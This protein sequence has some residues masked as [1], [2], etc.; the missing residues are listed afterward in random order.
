[1]N[2][3]EKLNEWMRSTVGCH[4]TQQSKWLSAIPEARENTT[5]N[6]NKV[7]GAATQTWLLKNSV[8]NLMFNTLYIITESGNLL[9]FEEV[10]NLYQFIY[11]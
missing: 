5:V 9:S 6:V 4:P 11:M 10:N 1:M 2:G 8:F 7:H 3:I